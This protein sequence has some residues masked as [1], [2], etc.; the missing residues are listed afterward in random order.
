MGSRLTWGHQLGVSC[1]GGRLSWQG[2]DMSTNISLPAPGNDTCPPQVSSSNCTGLFLLLLPTSQPNC[3]FFLSTPQSA[4]T[5]GFLV[6][7]S[8]QRLLCPAPLRPLS[9]LCPQLSLMNDI[10]ISI[11]SSLPKHCY[12]HCNLPCLEMQPAPACP[13]TL[14]PSSP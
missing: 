13:S 3:F 2:I 1:K 11:L 8:S 7:A 5:P 10:T 6:Y 14:T 9:S 4:H 12:V